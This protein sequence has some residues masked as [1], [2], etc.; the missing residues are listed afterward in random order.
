MEGSITEPSFILQ[1]HITHRCNLRC[2]H[3][4]QDDYSAFVSRESIASVL[5]QYLA[6]LREY[7]FKGH[8]NVTG[9]E[10]LM[11]P[12]LFYLLQR[13][14]EL[15][16]STAVL[17]NGT[18]LSASEA[19]RLRSCSV[20]YVQI[21]LDGMKKTHDAIRGEGS[22]ERAVNGIYALKAQGIFTTVAFTA[23]RENLRDFKRL[24]GYCGSL[25]VGKLWFDRV[26][27]PE[28][29]DIDK[30]TITKGDYA[31][32]CKTAAR[33]N[34]KGGVSCARALQFLPCADKKIYR[35]T[36]GKYLLALLADGTVMPCRRLPLIAGSIA[37]SSLPEIYRN[38]EI[39][40][41]LRTQKIPEGCALC[42]YAEACGGGAKCVACAKSGKTNIPDPD[43]PRIK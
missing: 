15:G 40:K 23:Q 5:E 10:P 25:G 43:C 31:R 7:G 18:M 28:A 22:F 17:T 1:W 20:D 19:R 29:E 8:I 12:E 42:E 35:C 9:G 6:L 2:S 38:S 13:A 16:L 33:L 3:C 36:A 24:A 4:Y 26:V 14:K 37:E 32:L 34:K 30:L 21:S 41:S 39:L 27:I 11:H